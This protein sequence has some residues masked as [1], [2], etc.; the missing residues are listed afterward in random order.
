M[1]SVTAIYPGTFDPFTNGHLDIVLRAASMFEH[2]MIGVSDHKKKQTLFSVEE[3][4]ESIQEALK[5]VKNVSVKPYN[6]LLTQFVRDE[7]A[8]VIIR[9]L[10]VTSDFE[11]EFKM[12]QFINDQARE[13]E[14][15]Y[16]MASGRTLH[17]SSS[18]V[19][20]VASLGADVSEYLPENVNLMVKEAYADTLLSELP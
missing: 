18:M 19:K 12:Q 16:L 10:R 14:V 17:I 15:V 5:H 3:R 13:V 4:I 1:P 2:V 6:N 11:Y 9:G 20:E 7:R 8:Q